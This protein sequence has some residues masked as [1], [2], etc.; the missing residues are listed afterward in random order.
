MNC[1]FRFSVR[2]YCVIMES[3]KHQG[4]YCV[5]FH[6]FQAIWLVMIVIT[7]SFHAVTCKKVID[8]QLYRPMETSFCRRKKKKKKKKTTPG[9]FVVHSTGRGRFPILWVV[10]VVVVGFLHNLLGGDTSHFF[11][12]VGAW[13]LLPPPPVRKPM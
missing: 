12:L 2:G 8:K 9:I 11:K 1:L 7:N 10:V 6:L 3:K 13:L 5:L 4:I